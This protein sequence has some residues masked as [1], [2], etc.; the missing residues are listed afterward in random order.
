MNIKTTPRWMN[1]VMAMLRAFILVWIS[2]ICSPAFATAPIAQAFPVYSIDAS[3]YGCAAATDANNYN[4][5]YLASFKT[6]VLGKE[7]WLFRTATDMLGS[8]GPDDN[9]LQLLRHLTRALKEKGV[10]LMIVYVPTRGLLHHRFFDEANARTYHYEQA[11]ANYRSALER[12]RAQGI[13]VADYSQLVSQT[14]SDDYYFKRDHHW[15]PFGAKVTARLV[16]D[17]VTTEGPADFAAHSFVNRPEGVYGREGTLQLAWKS[18]CNQ[19]FLKQF[20]PYYVHE[21]AATT[22]AASEDSLFS[23]DAVPE[24]ALVGTSFSADLKFNFVG[25]LREYLHADIT[26]LSIE[27]GG[28]D[29]ALLQA[30]NDPEF[31]RN[32]PKLLIWELPAYYRLDEREFYRQAMPLLNSSC[33]GKAPVLAESVKL[34]PGKNEFLFNAGGDDSEKVD[35][36]DNK[37]HF[38][39]M[40]FSDSG[41]RKLD[42]VIWHLNGRRDTVKIDRSDTVEMN[43]RFVLNL[44]DE[45]EWADFIYLSSEITIPEG[46]TDLSVDV[47]LCKR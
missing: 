35:F 34:K 40:Q 24:I 10:Q 33:D 42:M 3:Q 43:G 29:G 22:A 38:I 30:L 27:G 18:L 32:P 28:F 25:F 21:R 41:F 14:L 7:D 36:I 45:N 31:L 13:L 23:D 2:C 15:S 39:E 20:V 9:S 47:R 11:L 1:A 19:Q 6:L 5:S 4:T 12:I 46:Y 8:F 16:A 17:Y 37:N 26:N 44:K